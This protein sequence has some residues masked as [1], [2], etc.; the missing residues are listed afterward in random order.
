MTHR[1]EQIAESEFVVDDGVL[2][3]VSGDY[4]FNVRLDDIAIVGEYTTPAGP[5]VDDYFLVFLTRKGDRHDASFYADGRERMLRALSGY[6]HTPLTLR[7]SASDS[8]ASSIV[9][10]ISQAGQPLFEYRRQTASGLMARLRARLSFVAVEARLSRAVQQLL[11][12]T[13][14]EIEM[15]LDDA[16]AELDHDPLRALALTGSAIERSARIEA[17]ETT[18]A[19]VQGRAWKEHGNALFMT[20]RLAEALAAAAKAQSILSNHST[21]A[22]ERAAALLLTAL[23]TNEL[24]DRTG[25]LALLDECA[26]AFEAQGDRARKLMALEIRAITLFDL[27]Q[28][29]H[30][31][32]T[33]QE[34]RKL[35]EQLCFEADI[36]RIDHNIARSLME[37]G[38]F[39]EARRHIERAER[40]FADL[41]ME[42]EL[43]RARWSKTKMMKKTGQAGEALIELERLKPEFEQRGMDSVRNR[44]EQDIAELKGAA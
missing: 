12:G 14:A 7:L 32:A 34:A 35:A 27:Q 21:L 31:L 15:L 2:S 24:G 41:G 10:P 30:A 18:R 36:A 16:R 37:L 40:C 33:L 5:A 42:T 11:S 20:G 6:W 4:R 26:D 9:W 43:L 39:G 44:V 8:A 25:A 38:Q 19:R 29:E 17:D 23:V 22:S 28:F 3:Y 13:P 1:K